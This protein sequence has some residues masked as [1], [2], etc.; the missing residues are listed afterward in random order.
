MKFLTTIYSLFKNFFEFISF[1]V[2]PTYDSLNTEELENDY[3][4]IIF[5][6]MRENL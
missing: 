3:E 1:K 4:H 6:Q 5:N 2:K